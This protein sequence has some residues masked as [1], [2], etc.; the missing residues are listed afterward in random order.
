MI[1]VHPAAVPTMI[2]D[3]A[4]ARRRLYQLRAEARLQARLVR[5][6]EDRVKVLPATAIPTAAESAVPRG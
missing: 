3:P 6:A 5:I 2:P 4:E 1:P